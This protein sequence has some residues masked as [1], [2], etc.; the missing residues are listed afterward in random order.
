MTLYKKGQEYDVEYHTLLKF[1]CF[2]TAE[3]DWSLA[4]IEVKFKYNLT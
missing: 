4:N 1:L 2:V 3:I